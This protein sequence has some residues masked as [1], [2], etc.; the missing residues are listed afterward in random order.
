M[1]VSWWSIS[2]FTDKCGVRFLLH[3]AI[4]FSA[5]SRMDRIKRL[6]KPSQ[7]CL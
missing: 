2:P 6:S 1:M 7:H 3:T 4:I 5:K